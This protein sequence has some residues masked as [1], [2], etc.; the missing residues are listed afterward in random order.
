[1]TLF[2]TELSSYQLARSHQDSSAAGLALVAAPVAALAA[3]ALHTWLVQGAIDH[4]RRPPTTGELLLGW[5][6][7]FTVAVP[8][9]QFV[10]GD[11]HTLGFGIAWGVGGAVVA[12]AVIALVATILWR[13]PAPLPPPPTVDGSTTA[14]WSG[15]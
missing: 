12:P 8:A 5:V 4:D 13:R 2:G 10:P 3:Y 6:L 7:A 9:T 11:A 15:E 14:W 1:M